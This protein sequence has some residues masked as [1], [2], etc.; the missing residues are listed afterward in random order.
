[1]VKGGFN[2]RR[3][4][5]RFTYSWT[6]RNYVIEAFNDDKPYDEFIREQ[7]AADLYKYNDERLNALGFITLGRRDRDANNVIDDRIDTITKAFLGLTVSC[8]RCHDHKFDPVS[9]E[10]YYALHG[11]FNSITEPTDYQRPVSSGTPNDE[12]VKLRTERVNAIEAFKLKNYVEWY[13]DFKK[14]AKEYIP[15]AR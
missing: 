10:D 6:Y 5:P 8:A 14:G 13:D 15:H 2:N 11:I 4:D 3:D 7:L 12:Y 1:M 9:Q